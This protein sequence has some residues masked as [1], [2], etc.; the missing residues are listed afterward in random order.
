M[1]PVVVHIP[2]IKLTAIIEYHNLTTPSPDI[3]DAMVHAHTHTKLIMALTSAC[4]HS[5]TTKYG[6]YLH[7]PTSGI[8]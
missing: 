4:L 1:V 2:K 8:I 7:R 5:P 6:E 3:R